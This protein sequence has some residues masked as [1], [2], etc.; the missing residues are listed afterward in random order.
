[1]DKT[2]YVESIH[3]FEDVID[4]LDRGHSNAIDAC[5]LARAC[6]EDTRFGLRA[7]HFHLGLQPK[8]TQI[9]KTKKNKHRQGACTWQNEVTFVKYSRRF[10]YGV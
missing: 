8:P 1:M 3:T 2:T 9:L 7:L 5:V 10:K 6:E 4:V